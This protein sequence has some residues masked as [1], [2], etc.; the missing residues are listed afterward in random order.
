[1]AENFT[2]WQRDPFGVHE[3]RYIS[4]DGRP[5][6]LVADGG[7]RG[8]DAPATGIRTERPASAEHP[9]EIV[10]L[11]PAPDP[12]HS[13]ATG[14][15]RPDHGRVEMTRTRSVRRWRLSP[16]RVSAFV[17][18]HVKESWRKPVIGVVIC[19]LLAIG[20]EIATASTSGNGPPTSSLQEGVYVSAADPGGVA[21]FASATQ[22]DPTIASDY[23]PSNSF[24]DGMDGSGGE[25]AWIL[26]NGWSGTPYTLSL[27]VPIIPTTP[28]GVPQGTL[29]NGAAG[30]YDNYFVALGENLVAAGE[31]HIYLRL[32]W[33]FDGGWY[34][35]SATTPEQEMNY[36]EY[37]RQIVESMRQVPGEDFK[38]VWNP[39]AEAFDQLGYNVALA[40]PGNAYVDYIGVDA[41][42]Q[43]WVAPQTPINAW[44][45]TTFPDLTLADQFAQEQG[46]PLAVPEWGVATR[47][48]GHG[49]G[50]DPR[51]ITN[52]INWM[53]DPANDVAYES[54]FDFDGSA[55]SDAI[56]DGN[57]PLSL[58]AFIYGFGNSNA[59]VT[60]PTSSPTTT[61]TTSPPTTTTT[62]PPATTP[63]TTTP[64]TTTPLPSSG[65]SPVVNDPSGF[66]IPTNS[67]FDDEFNTGSLNT[68]V[69]APD[70]FGSG[71]VSNGT[72]ML[73]SN[74]SVG[75]N[76]LALQL[77]S[78]QSG[79]LV[80]TNPDD[81]QPG[82]SGFQIAPAPGAPVFV[83]FKATLPATAN[84]QVA[85][86]PALWLDGQTWPE[87]GEIDVMEGG[88][89]YTAY[90]VHYG[91][92][93]G[94][95]QGG[96]A[97]VNNGA[98]THT[99]GVL[100]STTGLTFFYDGAQVGPTITLSLTSPMYLLME[101][102]YS[103]ADPTLLPATMDVRYVR[104]WN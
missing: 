38:F 51:Y 20:G 32:G 50:D 62:T 53:E 58:A 78:P 84:G 68:S 26:Q 52:M 22:T 31:S 2:G 81:G 15:G 82:H 17:R 80:S 102:S 70:W 24:W 34:A 6:R 35:W 63:T 9:G 43:T 72:V 8:Y 42:D 11:Q 46:K 95:A 40:Y 13:A 64:T 99:Y 79:G 86:W 96:T 44:N 23:L 92:G 103:S 57:Y 71:S 12:V 97:D 90:H 67:V 74:V 69:W 1:M 54:Y 94:T 19:A 75:A 59:A 33:E 28:S 83:E 104:V 88:Y 45:E 73:S 25:L 61:T 7:R 4:L 56:T 85:N 37:F 16:A 14:I 30:L 18:G 49:L 65:D 87:D 29:A 47:S 36:A 98:G 77:N 93:D 89:G 66:D 48:D 27:G 10:P 41:Y 5:T 60:T 76:G 91:T 39:D 3:Y 101:N 55:Q 21:S 100:W